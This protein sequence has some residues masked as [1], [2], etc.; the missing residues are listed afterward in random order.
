[1][2]I[3]ILIT[4]YGM[5]S[6]VSPLG[7]VYSFGILFLEMLTRLRPTDELFNNKGL[8][9]RIY[10][11]ESLTRQVIDVVDPKLYLDEDIEAGELCE[12]LTSLFCSE[13]RR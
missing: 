13:E 7:D 8:N 10:A 1:M 3:N 4:E 11:N 12:L 2:I 9:I 6:Q 5:R